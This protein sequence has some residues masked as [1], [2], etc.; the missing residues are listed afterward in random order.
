MAQLTGMKIFAVCV[1]HCILTIVS[2]ELTKGLSNYWDEQSCSTELG[3][4]EEESFRRC[5]LKME[6]EKSW[7]TV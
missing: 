6:G 1:R 2:V 3:V 7:K 4:A 5:G